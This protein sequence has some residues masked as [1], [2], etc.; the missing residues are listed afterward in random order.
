MTK[1]EA[2]ILLFRVA[3]L[4]RVTG[5]RKGCPK[6]GYPDVVNL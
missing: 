6:R 3:F 4:I 2:Y 1:I 5:T